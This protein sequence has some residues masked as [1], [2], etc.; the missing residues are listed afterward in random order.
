M[1]AP[2]CS[3]SWRSAAGL[4]D[5]RRRAAPAVAGPRDRRSPAASPCS[6]IALAMPA[7]E[8]LAH[9]RRRARRDAASSGRWR[10][11]GRR[12]SAV[13]RPPR[14]R[15]RRAA[16]GRRARPSSGSPSPASRSRRAIRRAPWRPSPPA[17]SRA[18]SC[19][20]SSGWLDGPDAP[21]A[22]PDD[23]PR[24][25]GDPRLGPARAR[26]HRVGRVAG[27][28]RSGAGAHRPIDPAGRARARAS[29]SWRWS[30]RSPSAAA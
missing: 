26:R 1:T 28:A 14:A 6:A 24:L 23:E 2:R 8:S 19:P 7:E 11:P 10:S 17:A 20:G 21:V 15:G 27:R 25:A 4:A 13:A 16:D 29:R 30:P 22:P 3:P 5:D 12:A 9:R 18:S